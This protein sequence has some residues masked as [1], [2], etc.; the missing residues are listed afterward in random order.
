[1]QKNPVGAGMFLLRRRFRQPSM[2]MRKPSRVGDKL[3]PRWSRFR[4]C[5]A[6]SG[7]FFL[8]AQQ[9]DCHVTLTRSRSRRRPPPPPRPLLLRAR[10][11]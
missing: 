4:L 5:F 7:G 8:A 3:A 10:W 6:V 9:E 1:M 11:S 2:R